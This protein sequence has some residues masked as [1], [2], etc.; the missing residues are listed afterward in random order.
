[1]LVRRKQL[2]RSFVNRA[3]D[4]LAA[5]VRGEEPAG[6]KV[7]MV[8]TEYPT[9]S[10]PGAASYLVRHVEALS[11]LGVE[12]DVI[13]LVSRANPFNHFRAW[14]HMRAQ[15]RSKAY[16]LVHAHFG[17]ASVIARLQGSIPLVVTYHGS[18]VMGVVGGNG[19]YSLKGRILSL[20][21]R[22]MSLLADEVI[23][24]APHLG[25][26]LP[27]KQY[28]VIPLGVDLDR[29]VLTPKEQ[30]RDRLEWPQEAFIVLFAAL[31]VTVP[32]KRF[33]LAQEAV[34]RL[35]GEIPISL[36]TASGLRPEE[37]PTYMCAAD[38]LLLTSV[39]EG[40]PTVVKEAM[41]CNLPVVC[42]D[43]GDVRDQLNGV[44]PSAIC[45]S[46]PSALAEGLRQV[47]TSKCR[48]NGRDKVALLAEPLVAARVINVY[49]DLLRR[50]T[51]RS[52]VS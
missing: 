20:I 22:L 35:E 26:R 23:V 38:V 28:H 52:A 15:M 25:R 8:S 17:H 31:D 3:G 30:A 49:K 14:K 1:M 24:V 43:V 21:S 41:A 47:F 50:N 44:E 19:Q 6:I 10:R 12:V 46:N 36:K 18:D 32:V 48:S 11:K 40:S 29:F 51:R 45:E 7:L 16:D 2:N 5:S 33:S 13:H 4:P 9:P 27:C 34:R 42:T 37:I 39:H